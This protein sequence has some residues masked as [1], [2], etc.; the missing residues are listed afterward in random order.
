MASSS[1]R[2]KG[3]ASGE[4]SFT[5]DYRKAVSFAAV[6]AVLVFGLV[7]LLEFQ[8]EYLGFGEKVVSTSFFFVL[9]FGLGY[10]LIKLSRVANEIKDRLEYMVIIFGLGLSVFPIVAV[11]INTVRVPL[12]WW[13]F[14]LL[15]VPVPLKDILMSWG[16]V[17]KGILDFTRDLRRQDTTVMLAILTAAVVFIIF[18]KSSFAIPYMPDS[19]PWQHIIGVKYV[20]IAE[21]Y[22][23]PVGLYV[24]HY[25][26]PY[27]PALDT[28]LGIIKQLNSS[29]YWTVKFFSQI[30]IA[31][32]LVFCYFFVKELTGNK[33]LALLSVL[34]LA[35]TPPFLSHITW[36]H[37][38][39]VV[40]F[41]P[42][43]YFVE[44]ARKNGSWSVPAI[45][46]LAS[47]LLI[48]PLFTLAS[49]IFYMIYCGVHL[50]YDRT[51]FKRLIT[52]GVAG[53][54]LA[55]IYWIP[56]TYFVEKDTKGEGLQHFNDIKSLNLHLGAA[57]TDRVYNLDD[58]IF[59]DSGSADIFTHKGLGLAYVLLI[60]AAL[61]LPLLGRKYAVLNNESNALLIAWTAFIFIAMESWALPI[62]IY[63]YRFWGILPLTASILAAIGLLAADKVLSSMKEVKT[64]VLAIIVVGVLYGSAYPRFVVQTAHW[65]PGPQ[66]NTNE[67]LTGYL[68]LHALKPDTRVYGYCMADYSVMGFDMLDFPWDYEV[69]AFRKRMADKV[70]V[71]EMYAFLKKKNYEYVIFD[72]GCVTR[73][74][75]YKNL[76]G[77][78]TQT[79]LD[80]VNALLNE[81]AYSQSFTL[82]QGNQGFMIFKIN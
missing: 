74:Q 60:L 72:S 1:R 80:N 3:K 35:V 48:Q 51:L 40:Q 59:V 28:L 30:I 64:I 38:Y 6:A 81:T 65:P 23:K 47:S 61:L 5:L 41:F 19:D 73:C 17:R 22:D 66:W 29:V 78:E 82:A 8:D 14:L 67:Q 15:S 62:S 27:P 44:K 79:C 4:S 25:I 7:G 58:F 39:S 31:S 26:A 12:A 2:L 70:G 63:P 32:G 77:K 69:D 45:A 46:C 56:Q 42:L 54:L 52:I 75:E 24:S 36:A 9:C 68:A 43:F 11:I 16:Q 21:T 34:F 37:A 76:Y 71:N 10:T 33:R 20:S 49:G 57:G 50:I 18:V 53:L 13:V 55:L